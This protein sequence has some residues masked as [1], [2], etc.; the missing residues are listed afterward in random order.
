[1]SKLV[2]VESP[3]KAKTIAKFLGKDYKIESSFGHIRDLPKSK[4]GIDIEHDFLPEYVIPKDSQKHVTALKKLAKKA[5]EIILATDEDREGEAISWHLTQALGLSP[6]KTERIVF[7]EITKT[8]I[9]RALENPRRLDTKLVDA[10]QARRILDRLVGYE[11]SPFL[12]KKIRRGLSA[13]R[14][15]SVALRLVVERER[16]IEKFQPQE[17]WS[18]EARLK[19]DS[20]PEALAFTARLFQMSGKSV[21]K[22][23]LASKTQADEVILALQKAKY[24]VSDITH[25]ESRRYPAA[26]FTTS[27]LQQEAARK[28]GLTARQTMMF[29]QQL[30]ETGYITYM[31]TD[32]VNLAETALAQVRQVI[33]KKFGKTYSLPSPRRYKTKSKGA[34]E[35]HEAIRPT[36][37]S[38]APEILE[39]TLEPRQ[40]KLYDLIWK[41]TL[42]SQMA[43]AV[44]DETAVD[45]STET[46]YE[47]R[48]NGQVM[49]FD[50]FIKVYMEGKDEN[51][52][53]EELPEGQLPALEKNDILDLLALDGK[54]HF[55]Q[56]PP[57]FSDATLVKV[58]EEYGIGR[59][60]TYAP[61]ISTILAR[62]YVE[63][64]ER[65]FYP[66]DIGFLVNDIL[67]EHFPQIVDFQFTA[68]MEEQLDEIAE[69]KLL[70]QPVMREFYAPFKSN[71]DK[72]MASVERKIEITDTPC[73]HCSKPMLKK[74]GRFGQFLACP[75]KGSKVTLPLP[76]EA[77]QIE[78]LE[79]K[80]KDERCPL[81]SKAMVVKRGRFG[82]FLGCS[83]YPNCKGISKIQNKTGFKCPNC[84]TGDIVEKKSRGRGKIFYACSRFPECSF[85]MN[86]KPENQ[87]QLET[88]LADWKSKFSAKTD[89]DTKVAK[90]K[91]VTRK[92]TKK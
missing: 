13:G 70:W 67:V 44:F 65:K 17:Y 15:Q 36:D 46:P 32:S 6:D 25:K 2:I 68:R 33:E 61:T 54:Q 50:G 77:A 19:K 79:E 83:D 72:K 71:L 37:L 48:A 35:A 53:A 29:A 62:G 10:Q 73:P 90:A 59:P 1:M 42:A 55:T 91:T 86:Q 41:R 84:T 75:E 14:V 28:M 89:P 21:K 39:G 20:A 74:F 49:K 11:L 3:T 27:T 38:Q 52:E 80:T 34:Q 63:R 64:R 85:L 69:G 82:Y 5:D 66:T 92:K 47:F 7:H 60:S 4:M 57:R 18:V 23:D 78:I 26:P 76:E 12:W 31:R 81:C 43:E 56:P 30:Y 58:L 8:A 16:E 87:E 45:I 24:K 88:A 51:G 22:F 40:A 9:E